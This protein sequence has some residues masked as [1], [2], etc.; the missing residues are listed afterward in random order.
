MSFDFQDRTF[1]VDTSQP[2]AYLS[3]PI[4]EFFGG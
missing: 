4:T 1:S 2:T 3:R